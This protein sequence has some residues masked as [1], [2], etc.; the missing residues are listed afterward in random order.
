MIEI[1]EDE[2]RTNSII[3]MSIYGIGDIKN[4]KLNKQ[5]RIKD[6]IIDFSKK[7]IDCEKNLGDPRIRV[8]NHYLIKLLEFDINAICVWFLF[9]FIFWIFYKILQKILG[10]MCKLKKFNQEKIKIN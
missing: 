10:L 8:L 3:N 5:I 6:I 1:I 4:S 9:G 7:I 2:E